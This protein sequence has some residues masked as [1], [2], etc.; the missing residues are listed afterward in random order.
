MRLSY[1]AAL[2]LV[3]CGGSEPTSTPAPL[4][5]AHEEFAPEV[6]PETPAKPE[7]QAAA[8]TITSIKN[9]SVRDEHTLDITDVQLSAAGGDLTTLQGVVTVSLESWKS[10]IDVRDA[11][12]KEVFFETAIN[13]TA[14][15]TITKVEGPPKLD[16]GQTATLN[17]TGRFDVSGGSFSTSFPIV[18][19]HGEG[20]LYTFGTGGEVKFKAA[21]LGFSDRVQEVAGLCGVKLAD[22]FELKGTFKAPIA[23]R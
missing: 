20:S 19:H 4:E 1:I 14:T 9:E 8:I 3:A 2:L 10:P 5:P 7:V 17:L 6:A 18:I 15:F 12:V 11:R 13:P 21:Q 16:V 22:D 23:S